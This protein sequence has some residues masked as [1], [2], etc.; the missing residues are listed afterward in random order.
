MRHAH[1][2]P[3]YGITENHNLCP[4]LFL[5]VEAV[6]TAVREIA[7]ERKDAYM[8]TLCGSSLVL[9]GAPGASDGSVAKRFAT[10]P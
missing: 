2:D 4:F 3:F 10:D 5:S 1:R 8:K 9:T 7:N 6:G